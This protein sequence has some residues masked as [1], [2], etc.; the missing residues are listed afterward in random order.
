MPVVLNVIPFK[1]FSALCGTSARY[2]EVV[3]GSVISVS[4]VARVA[5]TP[6][7]HAFT[8]LFIKVRAQ[9]ALAADAASRRARSCLFQ[10]QFLLQ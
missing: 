5:S 7:A 2:A 6:A 1:V 3:P 8:L 9:H 4:A 10:C